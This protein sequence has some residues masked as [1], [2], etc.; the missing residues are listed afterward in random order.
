MAKKICLSFYGGKKEGRYD[1]RPVKEEFVYHF[2]YRSAFRLARNSFSRKAQTFATINLF[3]L[4]MRF[5]L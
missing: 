5:F 3:N 2:G 4:G 1:Y